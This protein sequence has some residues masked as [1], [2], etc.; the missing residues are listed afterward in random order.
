MEPSELS[1][2]EQLALFAG[3]RQIVGQMGAALTLAAAM[4]PGGHV[5]ML[6]GATCD[7]FFWDLACLFGHGFNW[8]FNEP[9]TD[10]GFDMLHRPLTADLDL[11][12]L[13]LG[14]V[15]TGA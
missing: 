14:S 6:D 13:A 15:G 8:I 1:F 5:T 4:P 7:V 12:R 10:Y 3:A 9:L 2:P 11:L